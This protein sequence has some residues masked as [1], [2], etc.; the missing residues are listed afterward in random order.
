V[1]GLTVAAALTLLGLDRLAQLP[2]SAADEGRF[3][4]IRAAQ[5]GEIS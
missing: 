1:C 5:V 4:G 2:R 3:S